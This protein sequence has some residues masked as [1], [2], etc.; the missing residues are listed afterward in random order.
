[1]KF[2][3]FII[4]FFLCQLSY[5]QDTRIGIFDKNADI[6][7]PKNA[8]SS[9]Y[10]EASQAY[11]VKGSGNNIWFNRDEFQFLYKRINGDFLLT[12]NLP[13]LVKKEMVI[14]K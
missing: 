1:M 10:D 14:E 6:G 8:G 5:S 9:R 3:S 7:K 4:L 13:F 2:L 12:A 11:Y